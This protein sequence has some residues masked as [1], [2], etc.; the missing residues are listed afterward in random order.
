MAGKTVEFY[1]QAVLNYIDDWVGHVPETPP[2]LQAPTTMP[3]LV[4][5]MDG[6]HNDAILRQ[7]KNE[8]NFLMREKRPIQ[9]GWPSRISPLSPYRPIPSHP[10]YLEIMT[11]QRNNNKKHNARNAIPP[12]AHLDTVFLYPSTHQETKARFSSNNF[13]KQ[14][15][16]CAIPI[17]RWEILKTR[18]RRPGQQPMQVY[19]STHGMLLANPDTI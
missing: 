17:K 7:K 16:Y 9:Y 1:L 8:S 13:S 14:E 2:N 19:L 3:E 11:T 5:T 12:R 6:S 18:N 15:T 4:T 10:P